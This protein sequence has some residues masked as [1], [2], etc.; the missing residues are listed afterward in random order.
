MKATMM[1]KSS[2][3][4]ITLLKKLEKKEDHSLEDEIE[5]KRALKIREFQLL[6]QEQKEVEDD[7]SKIY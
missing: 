1:T 2:Y 4:G 5:R 3:V 6:F 7:S